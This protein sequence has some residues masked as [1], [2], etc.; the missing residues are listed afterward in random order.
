MC[1][2]VFCQALVMVVSGMTLT[3]VAET[4][5]IPPVTG[6]FVL[7][8]P[9]LRSGF[10]EPYLSQTDSRQRE[11]NPS[12]S[13]VEVSPGRLDVHRSD[14]IILTTGRGDTDFQQYQHFD[15]IEPV[16]ESDNRISR[17]LDSVFLPEEVHIGK[18]TVS[19][20]ILT[21]IKRKNPF[22]LINPIFLNVSW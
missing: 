8:E 15:I 16:H 12:S 1:R 22:C 14:S 2:K 3:V 10:T 19:C 5:S 13:S 20:S 4:N 7:P 6:L 17:C 18:T 11:I 21:A 9:H